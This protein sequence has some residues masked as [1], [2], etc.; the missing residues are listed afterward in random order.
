MTTTIQDRV[1][2]GY[3]CTRCGAEPACMVPDGFGAHGQLFRCADDC[4]D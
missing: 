1:L 3:A 4:A 2:D